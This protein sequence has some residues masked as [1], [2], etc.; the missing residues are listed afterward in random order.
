MIERLSEAMGE[1]LVQTFL[2]PEPSQYRKSGSRSEPVAATRPTATA[3]GS[4]TPCVGARPFDPTKLCQSA[5]PR[6]RILILQSKSS[7]L[8]WNSLREWL[9]NDWPWVIVRWLAWA[10][11]R[12]QTWSLPP[13]QRVVKVYLLWN[14]RI[15]CGEFEFVLV[16]LKTSKL[17]TALS[18]Y[19]FISTRLETCR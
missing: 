16:P 19:Q 9:S 1:P 4:E 3:A 6:A 7:I 18:W 15:I 5:A 8:F 13:D 2:T 14:L 12:T 17:K 11:T 10:W